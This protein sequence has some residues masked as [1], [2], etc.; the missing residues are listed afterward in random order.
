MASYGAIVPRSFE[1]ISLSK[2][3]AG[4]LRRDRSPA[5]P[6][7]CDWLHADC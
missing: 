6:P 7:D 5:A 3:R 2:N 4:H 1:S